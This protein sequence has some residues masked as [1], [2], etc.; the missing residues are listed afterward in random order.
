MVHYMWDHLIGLIYPG[1][2]IYLKVMMFF[3]LFTYASTVNINIVYGY[4]KLVILAW[5]VVVS[6]EIFRLD[7][8]FNDL[9]VWKQVNIGNHNCFV[10]CYIFFIGS[11]L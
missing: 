2:M 8:S 3:I 5:D 9:A 10:N 4:F 6:M 7:L 1:H 11:W